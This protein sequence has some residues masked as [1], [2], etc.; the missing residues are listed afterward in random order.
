MS[1]RQQT[2]GERTDV[3]EG[4]ALHTGRLTRMSLAP[5]PVDTGIV[6]R[7]TDLGSQTDVRIGADKVSETRLATTVAFGKASVQTVEHLLSA[8]SVLEIDNVLVEVDGPE[9]PCMDGSA[10]PFVLMLKDVGAVEQERYRRMI[11]IA[12]TVEFSESDGSGPPKWARFSPYEGTRY[13]VRID[14]SHPYIRSTDQT[15]VF[16]FG[17]DY[18]RKIAKARTFGFVSELETL[19]DSGLARGGSSENCIVLNGSRLL[20]GAVLRYPNEFAR[21]KLLDAIG[22][23]YACGHRI[24]GE[25]ESYKPGHR[26]NNMLLRKLLLEESDAWSWIT[27]DGPQ[28]VIRQQ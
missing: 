4:L 17:E 16:E 13:K 15:A 19:L 5:A 9:M 8:L 22:D 12:R 23:C 14:F 20:D 18:E 26:V 25:Y 11:R 24:I 7:R 21:H 2:I 28:P 6:F 10:I 27:A 1:E 3:Y